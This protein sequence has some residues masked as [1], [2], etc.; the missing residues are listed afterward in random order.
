MGVWG[1]WFFFW[2]GFAGAVLGFAALCAWHPPLGVPPASRKPPGAWGSVLCRGGRS[3]RLAPC[4]VPL[5]WQSGTWDEETSRSA[6]DFA[7][8]DFLR[9]VIP[10]LTAA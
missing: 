7:W 1:G 3:L 10:E 2:L 4:S 9:W 8:V 6:V 5:A